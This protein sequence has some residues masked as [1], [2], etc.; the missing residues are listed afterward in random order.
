VLKAA[1]KPLS[2]FP[3]A[4]LGRTEFA[5]EFWQ[6]IEEQSSRAPLLGTSFAV[7]FLVVVESEG[8]AEFA[9]Q[10]WE[11]L[12]A[13]SYPH[14]KALFLSPRTFYA[15]TSLPNDPRIQWVETPEGLPLWAVKNRGLEQV[16][17]GWVGVV[18]LGDVVSPAA[19][20]LMAIEHQRQPERLGFY[21]FECS[22]GE[23]RTEFIS[24][25]D[26]N[27]FAQAH[28][29]TVGRFW[30]VKRSALKPFEDLP[31]GFDEQALLL[32]VGTESALG[33]VPYYLY[34]GRR[35]APLSATKAVALALEKSLPTCQAT[36]QEGG[37]IQIRPTVLDPSARISAIVCFRDKAL[38]T[39]RAVESLLKSQGA[40]ALDVLLVNN[41]SCE[42]ELRIIESRL[43]D[44]KNVRL[45][46]FP[47][48]FNYARMH[49]WAV[50]EH[51]TGNALCFLNNDVELA[52]VDLDLWAS[53]AL[54][55]QVA[56]VGIR[57]HF[58]NGDLQHAGVRAWFGGEARLVRVGNSHDEDRRA[59]D[60]KTVFASTFAACMVNRKAFELLGGLREKE[61][62]N[63]FG[64]VAF[65]FEAVRQGWTNLYLGSLSGTH[66]ES[67]S[68]GVSY[69]YWEEYGLERDYPEILNRM[70]RQDCGINRVPGDNAS[71]SEIVLGT[72]RT[73][74]RTRST[75]LDPFK[76]AIKKFFVGLQKARRVG[77]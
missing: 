18:A 21:T 16:S 28:W 58:E 64:D 9:A 68:R 17:E 34:Y 1:T 11:S 8:A 25:S 29:N 67:S 53:W 70:L 71:I 41:G 39:I 77:Q 60:F 33:L 49:N 20:Y 36:L 57:L 69:E 52:G 48:A 56:T 72:L 12:T 4:T 22:L 40:V 7:T 45:V 30:L 10:T 13:Q 31:S 43:G 37:R 51:C 44:W 42:S 14:W 47:G 38:L 73:F 15:K 54:Q 35:Q 24:K 65:C 5:A 2:A 3:W 32:R 75:W 46:H 27:A 23:K 19:L 74:F 59:F 55:P 50:R 6:K 66:A 61:L 62:V 76:P 63:G 26:F